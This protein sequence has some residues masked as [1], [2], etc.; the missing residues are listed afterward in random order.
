MSST[1]SLR[2]STV[3]AVKL[4]SVRYELMRGHSERGWFQ[5]NRIRPE[6]KRITPIE[7]IDDSELNRPSSRN[8][9]HVL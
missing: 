1:T 6:P 2:L 7:L 4:N 3:N 8:R 9:L 5:R